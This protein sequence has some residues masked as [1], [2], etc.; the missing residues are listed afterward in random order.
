MDFLLIVTKVTRKLL[1]SLP[2]V[3]FV[4]FSRNRRFWINYQNL[5]IGQTIKL[6]DKAVDLWLFIRISVSTI[7]VF[8]KLYLSFCKPIFFTNKIINFIYVFF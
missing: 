6:I 5:I 4:F 7:I 8:D 3:C 2:I 1:S